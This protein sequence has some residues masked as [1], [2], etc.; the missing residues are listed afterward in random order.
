MLSTSASCQQELIQ[1]AVKVNQ[2]VKQSQ[3]LTFLA[4]L[5]LSASQFLPASKSVRR[6]ID[7]S[8]SINQ[9]KWVSLNKHKQW[10]V[11]QLQQSL[12]A[13]AQCF[14]QLLRISFNKQCFEQQHKYLSAGPDSASISRYKSLKHL[15]HSLH[16]P[17]QVKSYPN[18]KVLPNTA[19]LQVTTCWSWIRVKPPW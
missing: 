8:T 3:S 1:L 2:K 5:N 13:T 4:T 18:A 16:N 9:R 7:D 15:S 19:E 17:G 11:S 6:I 12:K 10:S 14:N